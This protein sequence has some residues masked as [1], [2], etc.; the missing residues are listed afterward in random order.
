MIKSIQWYILYN[1][2]ICQLQCSTIQMVHQSLLDH[3]KFLP[4]KSAGF[5]PFQRIIHHKVVFSKKYMNKALVDNT[6]S[7]L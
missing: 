1:C 6:K 5:N 7:T 2:I 3:E 4:Y